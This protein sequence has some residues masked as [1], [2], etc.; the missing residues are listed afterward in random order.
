M[1]YRAVTVQ[2]HGDLAEIVLADEPLDAA[3]LAAVDATAAAIHDDASI[4]A[5]L[6]TAGSAA[7]TTPAVA[8]ATGLP[9]RSLELLGPPVIAAID[10]AC[11]S[12]GLELALACDARIASA[13]A[14]FAM[15]YVASGTVPSLGATVRL[16]RIAGRTA[17][18]AMILLGETLTAQDALRCGLVN[19]V[20]PEGGAKDEAMRIAQ[21][22]AARGPIAVRY[23]K[24]TMLRGADMT[25]EAALRYETDLTV[26]LQTTADRAEGVA[27]FIEKRPPKFD[28]R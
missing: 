7:W 14:T 26:I 28:G 24:E 9:F 27:A 12:A 13:G 4:H 25:L 19:A 23:A 1:T 16:P 15:P 5:V 22:I 11:S 18:A 8:G 2:R 21:T 3:T 17:A 10:A 6:L 20:T